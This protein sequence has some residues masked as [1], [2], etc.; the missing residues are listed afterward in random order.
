MNTARKVTPG[1]LPY[2]SYLSRRSSPF[3]TGSFSSLFLS[4]VPHPKKEKSHS[5]GEEQ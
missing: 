5:T 4:L 3:L 2:G 1:L